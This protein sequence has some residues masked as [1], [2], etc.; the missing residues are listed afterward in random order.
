[1]KKRV[2]VLGSTG[3]VGTQALDVMARF[4]ERFEVVGLCAGRGGDCLR[5]QVFE[6][7]PKRVA[8]REER[9]AESLQREL[10]SGI[11]VRAGVSGAS[12]VA[13]MPEADFVLAAISGGAG[14]LPTAA[15]IEAGK[16]VGIANKESLVLAGE[17]LTARAVQTG[18]RLLPIDSE[19]SAIFQC[20]NGQSINE[21]RRLWLTASG[22]PFWEDSREA[23]ERATPEEALRHPNWSMGNKITVDSA[24]LMNKG[25]EVIEARWLFGL[26]PERIGIV[27]HPQSI[28]HSMVEFC[29]G[30][31]VAQLG[32]SDMRGPIAYALS[33]PN[34]L[35][36]ELP[37]LDLPARERLTF[38]RPDPARF[39]ATDLAYQALALGGTA[40]A[41]LS[42]A[43]EA[44]V[45]AF[46]GRT[47]KL[48]DI[49]ET[50]RRV[51]EDHRV[52]PLRSIEQ[53]WAASEWGRRRGAELARH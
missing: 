51:L 30:A 7:R 52:E 43:D 12:W 28:V 29:D 19:H 31:I 8:V 49:A 33:F 2:A 53:A 36:L 27:V 22:G 20:L 5:E 44:L 48:T 17:L 42:G 39:P 16:T 25:L 40:P 4:P 26:P 45:A 41:A 24:T 3:S 47:V 18:A 14:M 32:V 21:V 35:P 23:M 11:E 9:D 13:A 37:A 38:A 6:W 15:A 10:P 1:M 46:L 34:R 50:C